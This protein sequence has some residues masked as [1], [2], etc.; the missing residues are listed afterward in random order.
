MDEQ[1]GD[2]AAT[3]VGRRPKMNPKVRVL[4]LAFLATVIVLAILGHRYV[5]LSIYFVL[6]V[7]QLF[8]GA[9][10]PTVVSRAGIQRPWRQLS[11]IYWEQV[12]S[13]SRPVP[14]KFAPRLNLVNG[15]S[16]ELDDIPADQTAHIAEIGGQEMLLPAPTGRH[17]LRCRRNARAATRRSRPTSNAGQR[18]SPTSVGNSPV[19]PDSTK[20]LMEPSPDASGMMAVQRFHSR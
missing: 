20:S 12:S 7:V 4:L 19:V 11:I 2:T 14:G 1:Q 13:V 5:F 9:R 15:K 17:H 16:I 8:L 10:P 18:C 6:G 3:V